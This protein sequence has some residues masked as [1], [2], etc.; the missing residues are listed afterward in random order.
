M[1]LHGAL[2]NTLTDPL[3]L[4][5]G[6]LSISLPVLWHLRRGKQTQAESNATTSWPFDPASLD[7][8]EV[9]SSFS[10]YTPL[11]ERMQI[12]F[13]NDLSLIVLA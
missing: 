4:T 13:K 3:H 1:A 8:S 11:F 2:W 6:I 5:L 9:F 7:R 12:G 10:S